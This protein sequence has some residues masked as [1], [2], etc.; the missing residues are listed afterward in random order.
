MF[1]NA[2]KTHRLLIGL[3]GMVCAAALPGGRLARGPDRRS[4]APRTGSHLRLS[5]DGSE[6]FVDGAMAE[7]PPR[8]CVFTHNHDAAAC[9]LGRGGGDRT[10]HGRRERFRR[11]A[12]PPAVSPDRPPRRR[13]GQVHRQRRARLLLPRRLAAQPLHR[14]RRQRHLHHRRREQRLRR[15]PRQR[16]LP[17]QHRQRR[18]LGRPRRRRLLTWAPAR[19]A[20]TA[21]PATTAS[22]ANST[23][24]SSTA[25]KASTTATAGWQGQFARLRGRSPPLT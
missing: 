16:L 14:R 3:S 20:A 1:S 21:K 4:K 25:A 22:T 8:G 6:I 15:R 24:T 12:R 18:L 17:H 19:T 11:S 23:P 10:E 9:P 2:H 13:P 5:S 7:T